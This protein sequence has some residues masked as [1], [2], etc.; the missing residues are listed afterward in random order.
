MSRVAKAPVQIPTGVEITLAADKISVKGKQGSLELAIHTAVDIQQEENELKFAPKKNDK[1][2]NAL[3]GTFRALVNN[4]VT[5]VSV[6][7]E[8]KL[9]L[10]GV[11]YRAKS[12][13]KTLNLSLG[14]SHPVDYELPEGVT[15][16]TPSQTEV[17]IKGVDKQVVG[18]IAAEIRGYRPPEP[19]KGKG[20][21]YADEI[22]RR[23]EAKKK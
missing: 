7:F 9:V 12:S 11:G 3:A 4:M 1:Q 23:K 13:G 8:K 15:C 20:V 2:S 22:V 18:Q 17:V 19:Y 21:R 5:G 6:G 16:E 10:Q 14:F